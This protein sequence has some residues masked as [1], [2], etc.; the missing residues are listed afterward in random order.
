MEK[1][2]MIAGIW[3]GITTADKGDEF[4]EYINQTGVPGLKGTSGNRGVYVLRQMEET[5]AHFI[6]ISLW[7]SREA[8][9]RFAGEEIEKAR[10]YPEYKD[11][12]QELEPTVK[13]YEVMVGP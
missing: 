9:V 10:Y 12:L 3:H 4:L 13:H 6:M 11:F 7:D 8:I 1:D 5:E 2:S